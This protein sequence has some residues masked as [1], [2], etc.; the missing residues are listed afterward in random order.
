MSIFQL[1]NPKKIY[2]L[3]KNWNET[4]IWSYLQGCMGEAFVDDLINPQ[5]A[6]I[7]IADFCF[8]AGIVNKELI[9]NIHKDFLI[10]VSQ[11]DKWSLEIEEVYGNQ[12][13]IHRRYALLKEPHVF[14]RQHLENIVNQLPSPY[15]IQRINK[16]YY[17]EILSKKWSK[18]LCI[19]FKNYQ[20]YQLNGLG[21]IV[22]Y[23]NEIV[24]GASS[25]T[26]FQNGIEIE[27]DTRQDYRRR[28]LAKSCGAKL[29]LECLKKNKYPSWDAHNEK[30]LSLAY[31]LG[32]H[33]DRHYQVYEFIKE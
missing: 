14:N 4:M 33:L 24:A 6:Q 23:E 10:L 12:V 17:E 15:K 20:D 7:I 8:F 25:Y 13:H 18:D 5:S 30:S 29:I 22:L 31:Q 11:D 32:Y 3:Y 28:G 19:H 9:K 16:Q 21:Y 2:H 27:I 1:N 26:Y